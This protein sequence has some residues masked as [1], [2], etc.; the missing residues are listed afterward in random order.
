MEGDGAVFRMKQMLWGLEA[1][2]ILEA[3]LRS[4]TTEIR[5]AF[6]ATTEAAQSVRAML[7][8]NVQN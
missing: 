8:T 5:R 2:R 4:S 3:K 6:E 7:L 1:L